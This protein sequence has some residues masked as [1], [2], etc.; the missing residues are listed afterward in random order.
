MSIV[1]EALQ[2]LPGVTPEAISTP[3]GN[4]YSDVASSRW[5]AAKIAFARDRKIIAGYEDNTFRPSRVVTRAELIAITRR[6]AE[7][8]KTRR[9]QDAQLQVTQPVRQFLDLNGHWSEQVVTQMSGY[10][11]VASP[12]NETGNTFAPNTGAQRNYAAAAVLR[13]YNCVSKP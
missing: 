1:V 3:P 13:M 2:R 8:A 5:S 6:A 12:L 4:P 11:G 7:Y 9:G 10:C